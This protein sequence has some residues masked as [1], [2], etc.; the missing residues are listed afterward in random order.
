MWHQ[1]AKHFLLYTNLLP[2]IGAGLASMATC[3]VLQLPVNIFYSMFLAFATFCSYN[4]H[5]YFTPTHSFT[6]QKEEWSV[7]N[8]KILASLSLFGG[9]GAVYFVSKLPILSLWYI[10]PLLVVTFIYTAPKIPHPL[11]AK[12][13]PMVRG[14]TLYLAFTWLYATVLI[15]ISISHASYNTTTNQYIAYR[16]FLFFIVCGL[17]DYRD[18]VID[19]LGGIKSIIA[20]AGAGVVK[21]VVQILLAICIVANLH[22]WDLIN[23]SYFFL[24]FVPILLLIIFYSSLE[25]SNKNDWWYYGFLDAIVFIVPFC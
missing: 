11:F 7:T 13:Q 1:K 8:K 23:N 10:L 2:A 20:M 5:W 6:L 16:F 17:F 4:L 21:W 18:R 15:P 19:G 9:I 14:K 25:K 24:H 3:N 22:L 12:L